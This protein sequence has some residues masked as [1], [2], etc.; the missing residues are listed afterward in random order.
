MKQ[1]LNNVLAVSFICAPTVKVG[2]IVEISDAKTVA[3]LTATN[4]IKTVGCVCKHRDTD[5]ECTVET[6]FRERRDD[7]VSGEA[8][9][10][11]AFVFGADNTIWQYVA[12]THDPAAI[13]GL[14]I[15]TA[16][17]AG[18]IVETLEL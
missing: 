13:A 3:V 2:D 6:R 14:V 12:A 16:T 4:S 8:L 9:V 10:V 1:K 17:D 15:T 5:T 7:R 11:G 18:Q